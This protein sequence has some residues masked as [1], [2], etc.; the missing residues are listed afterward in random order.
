MSREIQPW[1]AVGLTYISF[2]D[3]NVSKEF[4]VT[5]ANLDLYHYKIA[6]LDIYHCMSQ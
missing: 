2:I 1:L 3:N 5:K 6:K 4:Q